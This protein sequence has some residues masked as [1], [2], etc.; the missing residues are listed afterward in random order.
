MPSEFALYCAMCARLTATDFAALEEEKNT[1]AKLRS[2]TDR[3]LSKT[4]TVVL[5]SIN[6]VKGY[7]YELWCLARAAGTK[8][9]VLWIDTP[10]DTCRRWNETRSSSEVRPY[11]VLT[12]PMLFAKKLCRS[13]DKT[14][15]STRCMF[16]SYSRLPPRSAFPEKACR[17]T[18]LPFLTT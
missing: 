10:I 15:L 13:F 11:I 9:C 2:E 8:C 5:D 4:T 17:R 18:L 1:R 7:R 6:N 3:C 14:L 12:H 16:V